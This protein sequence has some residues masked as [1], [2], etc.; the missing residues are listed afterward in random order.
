MIT[1]HELEAVLD[2][3]ARDISKVYPDPE[4]WEG[5]VVYFF[6]V[7]EKTAIESRRKDQFERMLKKLANDIAKRVSLG[8]W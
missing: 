7:M 8:S 1:N 5:W 3:A 2:D 6:E 4:D